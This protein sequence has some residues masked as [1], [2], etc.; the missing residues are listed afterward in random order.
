V[1]PLYLLLAAVT[2]AGI[3]VQAVVNARLRVVVGTPLWAAAVQILIGLTGVL[4]IIALTRQPAPVTAGLDRAPWWVWTGGF[5]GAAYVVV[6]ILLTP[7]LGAALMLASTIVGQLVAAVLIDHFGW[8]GTTVF[9]ISPLRLL[10]VALLV[11]GVIL[12]RRSG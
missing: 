5:L 2:G 12:I 1:N 3:A 8:F 10:G 4:A 6:S 9:R 7:R 11:A